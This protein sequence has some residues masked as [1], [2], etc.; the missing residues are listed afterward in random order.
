MSCGKL[1]SPHVV[2]VNGGKK[3]QLLLVSLIILYFIL[4]FAE[5]RFEET[6]TLTAQIRNV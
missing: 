2:Q 4:I 5:E 3:F 1:A 6:E